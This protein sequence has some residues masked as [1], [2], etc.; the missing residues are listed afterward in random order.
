MIDAQYD[1]LEWMKES[2]LRRN[3]L[4]FMK[5]PSDNVSFARKQC[6]DWKRGRGQIVGS[7]D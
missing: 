2:T 4:F 1:M 5:I 6:E 3:K 7:P